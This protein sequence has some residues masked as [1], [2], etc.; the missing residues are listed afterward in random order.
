MGNLKARLQ[1]TKEG[2]GLHKHDKNVLDH[3]EQLDI[4]DVGG[5]GGAAT[6]LSLALL[7][8]VA[9]LDK[10]KAEY[11]VV[12]GDWNVRHPVDEPSKDAAGRWNTAVVRRFAQSR[13]LVEPPKRRLDWGGVEPRTYISGGNE[14]W[15]DLVLLGEQESGGQGAGE[16][17]RSAD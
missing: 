8:L 7:D 9:D 12:L 13:G 1:R 5:S 17:S 16:G 11:E 10:M 2:I 4:Q 15:I 6:P 3:L 14:S